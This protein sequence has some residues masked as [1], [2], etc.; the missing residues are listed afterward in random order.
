MQIYQAISAIM[1]EVKFVE[2][3]RTNSQQGYKFR[4]ID[5]FYMSFQNVLS[6]YGVFFATEV[7]TQE[8]E[9]RPS[10][11]GGTLIWTVLKVKF[12]VYAQDASFI[13]LV[14]IG[15]A[16]D[17]GDKSANKAMSAALKYAFIQLFCIPTEEDNDTE[18]HSPEIGEKIPNHAPI[19]KLNDEDPCPIFGKVGK[20]FE[21]QIMSKIDKKSLADYITWLK[22]M[23]LSD[24]SRN[25]IN[26][27]EKYLSK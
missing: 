16:M 9:E 4:G 12:K 21:N 26:L 20:K 13:E 23:T 1:K 15:E 7:L 3:N 5:D 24:D 17:T 11:G 19:V 10:K 2:K 27:V 25:W 22:G 6:K 18:N 8:R 14:T